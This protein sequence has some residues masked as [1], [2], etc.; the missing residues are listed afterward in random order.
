[1]GVAYIAYYQAM[2]GKYRQGKRG[3]TESCVD[4]LGTQTV[5]QGGVGACKVCQGKTEERSGDVA[6]N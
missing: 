2:R 3:A 1:M 4:S 5:V 6:R